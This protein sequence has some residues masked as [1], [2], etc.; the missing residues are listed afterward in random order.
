MLCVLNLG[1]QPATWAIEDGWTALEG[2][3]FPSRVEGGTLHLP[4]FGVFFGTRAPAG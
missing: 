2:H 1:N 4:A 3:G